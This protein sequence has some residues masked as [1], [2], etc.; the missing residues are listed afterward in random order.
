MTS[1]PKINLPKSLLPKDSNV[2]I[3]VDPPR[4]STNAGYEAY[5]FQTGSGIHVTP[6]PLSRDS[7][8]SDRPFHG[9]VEDNPNDL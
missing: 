1:K 9:S 4:P 8:R 5:K 6:L 7:S 2:S 3:A